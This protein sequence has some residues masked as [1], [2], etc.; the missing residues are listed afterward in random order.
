MR[1]RGRVA[2]LAALIAATLLAAAGAPDASAQGRSS[3]TSAFG[4]STQL[5]FTSANQVVTPINT[6]P[7][8]TISG[9]GP[10]PYVLTQA[11]DATSVGSEPTGTLLQFTRA[12]VDAFSLLPNS[13]RTNSD[14]VVQ[15]LRLTIG[16][17]LTISADSVDAQAIAQFNTESGACDPNV[18]A[19]L[20]RATVG[21]TLGTGLR[22]PVNP[23][24]NAVLLNGSGIRVV[25]N[26]QTEVVDPTSNSAT[27][28]TLHVY[29]TNTPLNGGTLNGEIIVSHS[30]ATLLGVRCQL[31]GEG[32]ATSSLTPSP[33]ATATPMG[34][35]T[36]THTPT[37]TA[38]S[39][40]TPT[41][42][43][44]PTATATPPPTG[45]PPPVLLG[46]LPPPPPPPPSAPLLAP[47]PPPPLL[48][49]P[50][51]PTTSDQRPAARSA[52]VPVIPE[53]DSL[54]LLGGGLLV[55]AGLAALRRWRGLAK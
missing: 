47:A 41:A 5:R 46:I 22:I 32:I 27:V 49:P 52:P 54:L 4:I 21:G 35:H 42:T 2:L 38:T 34:T 31:P 15:N 53:G 13:F 9:S 17:L 1:R 29:F 40:A 8:P 30:D 43:S 18:G 10:A 28:N 51:L 19:F 3:L 14:A 26:E 20:T 50:P 25:L 36:P 33:Q 11:A 39:T 48:P 12:R 7:V 44:T 24:P 23:A 45:T 55:V 16:N 37:A 6:A